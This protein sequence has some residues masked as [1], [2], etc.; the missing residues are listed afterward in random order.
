MAC[1]P[2]SD[3]PQLYAPPPPRSRPHLAPYLARISPRQI[4]LKLE[5]ARASRD[6]LAKAI[7]GKL[8]G[9]VVQQVNNCLMDADAESVDAGLLGILDIYGFENF[10]RNSLEQV[11]SK[12]SKLVSTTASSMRTQ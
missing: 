7:Y 2:R 10:E 3:S 1:A 11:G 6:A 5:E 12:Y 9:W 8:F 4:A